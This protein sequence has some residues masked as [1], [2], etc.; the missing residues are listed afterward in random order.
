MHESLF[1]GLRWGDMFPSLQLIL[2]GKSLILQLC[3][4]LCLIENHQK[5]GTEPGSEWTYEAKASWELI[6]PKL[7]TSFL[8]LFKMFGLRFFCH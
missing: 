1:Q 6:S 8:L 5:V 2:T 4:S 7:M 3:L